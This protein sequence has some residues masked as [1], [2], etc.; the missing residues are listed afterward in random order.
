M[1]DPDVQLSVYGTTEHS[2]VPRRLVAGQLSLEITNGVVRALCW[3]GVEVLRAIDYPV[4]DADWGTFAAETVSEEFTEVATS[5][6]YKRAFKVDGTMVKGWFT[7]SGTDL[8]KVTASLELRADAPSKV[9]R[10]GF[11]ILHPVMGVAGSPLH[12]SRR[13]GS[14]ELSAFPQNI[15]PHQPA[16]DIAGLRQEAN[17]VSA[18]IQFAG[19]VFEMEDQRNWTDASFKTY[20]RPLSLPFPFELAAGETVVQ[21]V[22]VQITGGGQSQTN[23]LEK[24][25]TLG[26]GTGR[27]LPQLA[28]ALESGWETTTEARPLVHVSATLLRLDLTMPGW[29]QTLQGLLESTFGVLDLE[30]IVSD[31]SAE[32]GTE[33]AMLAATGI[34]V[35]SILALPKSCLKTQPKDAARSDGASPADAAAAA[36]GCFPQSEIGGGF[37]TNFTELNR[38]P[39]AARLG[40]F[41]SHSTSAIV[42][43]ADDI[44]V[45]Q[46]L[47]A[48]PQV[49]ASAEALAPEKPY[50]LGLVSIGMRSNPYGAEVAPNPEGVR[51]PM[52]MIDPRQCGLFAAA[53]MVGAIAAT[54]TSRVERLALA[55]ACGPFGLLDGAQSRPAFH[56]HEAFVR[57]QDRPRL[58]TL[59]PDGIA[60][61]A[62]EGAMVVANL[63][64]KPYK[65]DLPSAMR[66]I[67]MD[68]LQ[69]SPNWLHWTPRHPVT[70]LGLPAYSVAFL[71]TGPDDIFGSAT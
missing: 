20:C 42:H 44:S 70:V 16:L 2:A 22:T 65:L 58:V 36:R 17:G 59:G 6:E 47:E 57:M 32:L 48:L 14:V 4:R 50:R 64:A 12:M 41:V 68:R 37:L 33:L 45:M 60:V 69:L 35:R 1:I 25:I 54:E 23:K 28:L 56:V 9:N 67:I 43:A 63:G 29:K 30:V 49:F 11:V 24:S 7:C 71:L 8:G 39:S 10:A 27:S 53:W 51:R 34:A 62:V 13:D 52:A 66:G 5:F 40:D 21:S 55:A 61:V 15:A 18:D 46:T 38:H 19:E 3:N 31:S 26:A